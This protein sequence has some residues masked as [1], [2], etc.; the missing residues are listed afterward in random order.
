MVRKR[1]I[2]VL[3]A[4]A[5]VAAILVGPL[6]EIGRADFTLTGTQQLTVNTNLGGVGGLYDQSQATVVPGGYL[7]TIWAYD[8]S[9]ANV[10]G[11]TVHGGG[12][13]N[14]STLNVYSGL[15]NDDWWEWNNSTV[16][17]SGGTV[18]A[19]HPYDSSTANVSGGSVGIFMTNNTS[20][21]N[22]TG[23]SVTTYL[24]AYDSSTVN[25]SGGSINAL[26]A[27][28]ASTV[29]FNATNFQLGQ[30]LS[31]NGNQVLGTGILSG[32]WANGT[33]WTVDIMEN[34]S[35]VNILVPEPATM[36]LLAVG[37][38]ALVARRRQAS[39]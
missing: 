17:V 24:A 15:V 32:D 8:D 19:L 34:D 37:L 18:V 27:Y 31:L 2:L 28:D 35:G 39:N 3:L 14:N 29:I 6:A 10:S 9:T 20:I 1:L 25:L 7:D 38:A 30:G 11:G 4:P 12:T 13:S 33:A 16:N 22:V 21:A 26:Y 23:G 36:G 5:F